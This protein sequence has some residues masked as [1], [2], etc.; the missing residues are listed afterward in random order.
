M[1]GI[2]GT[3]TDPNLRTDALRRAVER[4][5]AQ[6]RHPANAERETE[7][8]YTVTIGVFA[9]GSPGDVL[10]HLSALAR[11]F[12]DTRVDVAVRSIGVK[13]ESI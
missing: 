5:E 9:K 8:E 2:P 10:N 6:K 13:Q 12:G 4:D 11:N 7:R 3:I 1:R